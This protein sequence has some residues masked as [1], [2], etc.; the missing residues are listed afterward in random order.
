MRDLLVSVVLITYNHEKYIR[1]ALDSVFSQATDFPFEVVIGED[2]STDNTRSILLE[3]KEKYQDKCKLLFRKE[4]LGCPT[5]NVYQTMMECRGKYMAFLEGDDYWT[6]SYKLQKQVDFLEKHDEYIAVAHGCQLIDAEG[7]KINHP[8]GD[9]YQW[10]GKYTLKNF[11]TQDKWPGHYATILCRNIFKENKYDYSVL[12]KAHDFIDDRVILLFLLLQG[13]IYRTDEI[14]SAW[15]Y[16]RK[17][18]SGN[19]NSLSVKRNMIKEECYMNQVLVR[20]C[21]NNF[22]QTE[23]DV[24]LLKNNFGTALKMFLKK[25][26]KENKKFLEDMYRYN[27]KEVVDKERGRSLFAYSVAYTWNKFLEAGKK[28]GRKK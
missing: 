23:Y 27:I 25:P 19:W 8:V 12:Y 4:N 17:E 20:W 2:C 10:R 5:L 14:M 21:S 16:V 26:S 3:Y 7:H 9:M 28:H 22:G 24:M 18:G 6:D 1:K 11:V 15:R 13:N